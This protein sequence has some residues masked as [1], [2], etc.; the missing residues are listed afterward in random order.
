MIVLDQDAKHFCFTEVG[1]IS[2]MSPKICVH[3]SG[4]GPFFLEVTSLANSF[5]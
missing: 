2:F 1:C 4:N 5:Y 3:A